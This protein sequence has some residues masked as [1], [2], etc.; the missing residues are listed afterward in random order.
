MDPPA[1][2][3]A[4]D[5]A[6]AVVGTGTGTHDDDGDDDARSVDSYSSSEIRG[7][8][9]IKDP[10][11]ADQLA[12]EDDDDDDDYGGDDGGDHEGRY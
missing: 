7:I 5:G 3:T 12:H 9:K 1:Y 4:E 8:L 11:V 10:S 6:L 2:V